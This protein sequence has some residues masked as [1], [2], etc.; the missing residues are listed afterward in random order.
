MKGVGKNSLSL[1]HYINQTFPVGKDQYPAQTN[2][3]KKG[4]I[5]VHGLQGRL[6]S[7]GKNRFSVELA[8]ERL[9]LGTHGFK[10]LHLLF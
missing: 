2:L 10:L 8:S 3:S 6:N 9:E 7:N 5:M 1:N 4:D